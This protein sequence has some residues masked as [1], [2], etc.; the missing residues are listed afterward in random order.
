MSLQNFLR[1]GNLVN[2]LTKKSTVLSKI[3]P[4]PIPKEVAGRKIEIINFILQDVLISRIYNL[5][6]GGY[7]VGYILKCESLLIFLSLVSPR[8]PFIFGTY[9][10]GSLLFTELY[11]KIIDG[12]HSPYLNKLDIK[13]LMVTGFEI[14][15]V[16]F[17]L[18]L[19]DNKNNN[20]TVEPNSLYETEEQRLND[21]I[22]TSPFGDIDI[23]GLYKI[24]VKQTMIK[25]GLP[26][27][28]IGAYNNWYKDSQP[29]N[30]KLEI[31]SVFSDEQKKQIEELEEKNQELEAQKFN[32]LQPNSNT[33]VITEEDNASL[34]QI[35]NDIKEN[36]QSIET[37]YQTET[38]KIIKQKKIE[39]VRNM[40]TNNEEINAKLKES[41]YLS[42]FWRSNITKDYFTFLNDKRTKGSKELHDYTGSGMKLMTNKG[43]EDSG[44]Q[45]VLDEGSKGLHDYSGS[46]IKLLIKKYASYLPELFKNTTMEDILFDT[47]I[48]IYIQTN[49]MSIFNQENLLDLSGKIYLNMFKKSTQDF[50]N[51]S[52]K[53]IREEVGF[54]KTLF[55]GLRIVSD[56][57]EEEFRNFVSKKVLNSTGTWAV[58]NDPEKAFTYEL[59]HKLNVYNQ[60][61][62]KFSKG[63]LASFDVGLEKSE[64]TTYFTDWFEKRLNT[65]LEFLYYMSSVAEKSQMTEQQEEYIAK[66]EK[67][68]EKNLEVYTEGTIL[69][70]QNFQTGL[71]VANLLVKIFQAK[72]NA[73]EQKN[74]LMQGVYGLI[75]LYYLKTTDDKIKR[76]IE[77][78]FGPLLGKKRF[79]KQVQEVPPLYLD[80]H[81]DLKTRA[82]LLGSTV[83]F[84]FNAFTTYTAFENFYNKLPVDTSIQNM[85]FKPLSELGSSL[86]AELI[87]PGLL[88]YS[89]IR[90]INKSEMTKL[91]PFIFIALHFAIECLIKYNFQTP[92]N[93]TYTL[94]LADPA[95]FKLSQL[96]HLV[97]FM[98]HKEYALNL[99]PRTLHVMQ[100]RNL[101]KKIHNAIF[102]N[103]SIQFIRQVT[104]ENRDV[105]TNAVLSLLHVI[106]YRYPRLRYLFMN[107]KKEDYQLMIDLLCLSPS[108][109][110]IPQYDNVPNFWQIFKPEAVF[111]IVQ[112]LGLTYASINE[113][114]LISPLISIFS[115][116]FCYITPGNT[117][118]NR[119]LYTP[120]TRFK[121]IELPDCLN[122]N[123]H[124]KQERVDNY[125]TKEFD[126]ASKLKKN[127]EPSLVI[128][129]FNGA[130]KPNTKNMPRR[131][132]AKSCTYELISFIEENKEGDTIK[133]HV[134]NMTYDGKNW[135]SFKN[136]LQQ[137]MLEKPVA[138]KIPVVLLMYE[139][140]NRERKA[141]LPF[142][143]LVTYFINILEIQTNQIYITEN[144]NFNPHKNDHI[145]CE[146]YACVLAFFTL[147]ME[148]FSET[149]VKGLVDSL[150]VN[151][152]S[153]LSS[154][155]PDVRPLQSIDFL[156]G[157]FK[158]LDDN[159]HDSDDYSNYERNTLLTDPYTE[160]HSKAEFA[161]EKLKCK[162]TIFM[163][164]D[165]YTENSIQF[166]EINFGNKEVYEYHL[167]IGCLYGA[168][169]DQ[170][171]PVFHFFPL[172]E[173]NN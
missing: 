57:K 168:L 62:Q 97:F 103:F 154:K 148:S 119:I 171:K 169:S 105:T 151:Y 113:T 162:I 90:K 73:E 21:T 64:I 12:E 156:T 96:Q 172:K 60:I 173:K 56:V 106:W 30:V 80:S 88:V 93:E 63:F 153:K 123:M 165:I 134:T 14:T 49:D 45:E 8:I 85:P 130:K 155:N 3:E 126:P 76:R 121:E 59:Y 145:R 164:E 141:N 161:A 44:N 23:L 98:K 22:F 127:Q 129:I 19:I 109:C 100:T 29:L 166:K 89:A 46:D 37:I 61:K 91:E 33:Q 47:A 74:N 31:S 9:K 136:G 18:W 70:A 142:S 149:Q 35:N 125:D 92:E 17:T 110:P 159:F 11:K 140:V 95:F 54:W 124:I 86:G 69:P 104:E 170:P 116:L 41:L 115:L 135:C 24:I 160:F 137:V 78:T 107:N 83:G 32:R 118:P 51:N 108:E 138:K 7:H 28:F 128:F 71:R 42:S 13:N 52:K 43:V 34:H 87:I 139:N 2:F 167:K 112:M 38:A 40:L 111:A 150:K 84:G 1:D 158:Q 144:N 122:N 25:Y 55:G 6:I 75:D 94:D 67:S 117:P 146:F 16:A 15:C 27:F 4:E 99:I 39:E 152:K 48:Y 157:M 132:N 101:F 5:F 58:L 81:V 50:V 53:E 133:N 143:D 10:L 26:P 68:T 114:Y 131:F 102:P 82:T 65:K 36:L 72:K 20:I 66:L 120:V 77:Y 147:K 163:C 79:S